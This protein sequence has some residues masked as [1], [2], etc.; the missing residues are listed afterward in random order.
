MTLTAIID[1]VEVTPA[2]D[3]LAGRMTVEEADDLFIEIVR[4]EKGKDR[5]VRASGI[6]PYCENRWASMDPLEQGKLMEALQRSEWDVSY[7]RAST[8]PGPDGG[9]VVAAV[10]CFC[11]KRGFAKAFGGSSPCSQ[12]GNVHEAVVRALAQAY[13]HDLGPDYTVTPEK[14]FTFKG[15]KPVD[16]RPDISIIGPDGE[17]AIAIEFQRSRED[18]EGFRLRHSIRAR[19]WAEVVWFFDKRI[20][21]APTTTHARNLLW[22]AQIPFFQAWVD[23][24]NQ[25]LQVEEGT[26]HDGGR[27]RKSPLPQGCSDGRL[28]NALEREQEQGD[29][30]QPTRIYLTGD[31]A[32]MADI[33]KAADGMNR[34]FELIRQQEEARQE[35]EA[36]DKAWARLQSLLKYLFILGDR[37]SSPATRQWSSAQLAAE[38]DRLKCLEPEAVAEHRRREAERLRLEAEAQER[39]AERLRQA[40]PLVEAILTIRRR[41]ADVYKRQEWSGA[42]RNWSIDNLQAEIERLNDV[43]AEC[44]AEQERLRQQRLEEQRR[45]SQIQQKLNRIGGLINAIAQHQITEKTDAHW[46]WSLEQLEVEEARLLSIWETAEEAARQLARQRELLALRDRLRDA[47][48]WDKHDEARQL[49]ADFDWAGTEEKEAFWEL[50]PV[51]LRRWLHNEVFA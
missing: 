48:D 50:V 24:E 37:A 29:R 17:K 21:N 34:T 5:E 39:E 14:T 20:Y 18:V 19:E 41:L 49:V 51:G 25:R 47:R 1:G 44:E 27:S 16:Y 3:V 26:R 8:R 7:R 2:V 11:H 45:L 6:C 13:Q 36:R 28:I 46:G 31:G 42:N 33:R 15:P 35:A 10:M 38:H 4:D 23:A 40:I 9:L 22:D 32:L 30:P 43:V 12:P